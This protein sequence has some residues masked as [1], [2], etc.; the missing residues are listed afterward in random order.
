MMM[1]AGEKYQHLVLKTGCRCCDPRLGAFTARM[2]A[3]LSRRGFLCGA[4]AAAALGLSPSA[5]LAQPA[6]AKGVLFEN[7]RIFDGVFDRLS[8][9]SHV[10]VVGNVI[11]TI[12]K[13][14]I[15]APPDLWLTRI[16]GKGRTLSPGLIDVH[17]HIMFSTV[18]QM[19]I[20]TSDIGFV[21][22]AAVKETSGIC[23]GPR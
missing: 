18:P 9:P 20:L 1:R 22:I 4:G 21:N 19:A 3:D 2:N 16:D 15:A 14:P 7:V 23:S 10:L 11:K 5:A 8:A 6:Q 17:T 12:A 13:A